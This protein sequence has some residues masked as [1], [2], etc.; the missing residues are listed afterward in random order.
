[1]KVRRH[2]PPLRQRSPVQWPKLPRLPKM[3]VLSVLPWLAGAAVLGYLATVVWLFPEPILATDTPVPRVL[4]L[5]QAEAEARLAEVGLRGRVVETEPHPDAPAGT[6]TWQDPP[7]AVEAPAGAVIRLTISR[8]PLTR[9]VPDVVGLDKDLAEEILEAGGFEIGRVDSIAAL[10]DLGT[11]V[12]T[13]P[14][15]GVARA[16]GASVQ[17]VVSQG[18][19]VIP[20]PNVVGLTHREAWERLDDAGLHVG[21]VMARPTDAVEPGRVVEQRPAPGTRAPMEGRIDL[22][23]SRKRNP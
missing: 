23:F 15:A 18:P 20:V 11:I 3:G 19:A 21:R 14:A 22:I 10:S 7:P 17:L 1:M 8:G 9:P 5:A 6:V 2:L 13:R 16:P 4:D 12:V